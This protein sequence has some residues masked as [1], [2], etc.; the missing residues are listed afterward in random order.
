M[1]PLE[2][3]NPARARPS[4]FNAENIKHYPDALQEGEPVVVTEKLHG[5]W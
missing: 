2:S 5:T 3:W 4:S 1:P